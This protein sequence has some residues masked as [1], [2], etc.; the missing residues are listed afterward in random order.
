VKKLLIFLVLLSGVAVS[1]SAVSASARFGAI[2]SVGFLDSPS[3][4][5]IINEIDKGINFRPG[6]EF[7]MKIDRIGFGLN[8]FIMFNRTK[9]TDPALLWDWTF[10]WISTVNIGYHLARTWH[11]LDPFIEA[12]FGAAG[13]VDLSPQQ[14][15]FDDM[16]YMEYYGYDAYNR[17][18]N[19]SLIGYIAAGLSIRI[20]ML[21]VSGKLSYWPLNS[22]PPA[23]QYLAYP[24]K[25]FQFAISA[26]FVVGR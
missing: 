7:A 5:D 3:I 25:Q 1:V 2:L 4:S 20:N 21:Y 16:G 9:S 19:L 10:D 11:F 18:L 6:F 8:S 22:P 13:R 14:Y 17:L 15:S 23:T 12:G 24:V 26:G